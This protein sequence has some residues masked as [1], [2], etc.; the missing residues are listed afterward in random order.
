M[1]VD[2]LARRGTTGSSRRLPSSSWTSRVAAPR[3]AHDCQSG[4]DGKGDGWRRPKNQIRV[5]LPSAT[6]IS[7][8]VFSPLP[9]GSRNLTAIMITYMA[10][11]LQTSDN[12]H[13][14]NSPHITTNRTTSI[15]QPLQTL[16]QDTAK[17]KPIERPLDP[18]KRKRLPWHGC[19][20]EI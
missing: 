6:L 13:Y 1:F 12:D 7:L 2:S 10:G 9:R 16:P 4:V 8:R 20:Q 3:A 17:T 19:H 5:L 18:N 15:E 14:N 11:D